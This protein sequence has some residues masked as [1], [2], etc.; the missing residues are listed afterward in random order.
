[1]DNLEKIK[2]HL[3][4]SVPITFKNSD[5]EE[6]IIEFKPLNIGQQALFMEI[7]KKIQSRP[8]MMVE[9]I[10]VPEVT[11]EDTT[12]MAELLVDIVKN[13]IDGISDKEARDFVD[14]NFDILFDKMNELIP[15]NQ[16]TRALDL[17][18]KRREAQ[19]GSRIE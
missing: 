17:I 4:K 13:S 3:G 8:K 10:E 19:N 12:E 16:N 15:K 14:N 18:N 6:D 1:M 9:G 7:G 5:G 2:R 11:R